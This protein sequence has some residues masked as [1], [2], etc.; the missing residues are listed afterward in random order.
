MTNPSYE[1]LIAKLPSTGILVALDPGET[2]GYAI[3]MNNYLIETGQISGK[4]FV[5]CIKD[6]HR[7]LRNANPHH[8]VMEDYKIYSHKSQAHAWS[9]LFTPRLLG[10][11][12]T[13][14]YFERKVLHRQMASAKGFCTDEKLKKWNMFRVGQPHACDAVR[15]GVYFILFR[16]NREVRDETRKLGSR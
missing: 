1:K 5:E 13:L 6:L 10:A 12:E 8:V 16:S 2:T 9:S 7:L 11:I 3:F 4:N 15:H 14:C